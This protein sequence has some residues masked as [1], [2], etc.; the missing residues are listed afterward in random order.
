MIDD[1]SGCGSLV[2]VPPVTISGD[3]NPQPTQFS[4]S[5]VAIKHF[6]HGDLRL[7]G[8]PKCFRETG[9]RDRTATLQFGPAHRGNES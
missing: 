3:D 9:V 1:T 7:V 8:F 2:H 6:S 4:V 5:V